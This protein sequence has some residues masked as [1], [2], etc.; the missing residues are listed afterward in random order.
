MSLPSASPHVP[1]KSTRELVQA[2]AAQLLE[3]G[4][5]VRQAAIREAILVEHGISA[6]PNLVND[7][8][9]KFWAKAGPALSARLRRPGIPDAVCQ[10]FDAIWDVALNAAAAGHELERQQLQAHTE[11]ALATA[12]QAGAQA[13]A[14]AAQL[15]AQTEELLSLR[16]D[17]SRMSEQMVASEAE[18]QGLVR[19]RQEVADKV[20]AQRL[21]AAHEHQRLQALVDQ[22][23]QQLSALRDSAQ[24]DLLALGESHQAELVKTQDFLMLETARVRD[25]HKARTERLSKELEQQQAR[26]DQLRLLRA[27]ASDE[28]AELR[29][30]LQA[31]DRALAQLEQHNA[32][33]TAQ[34]QALQAA[35]LDSV[36]AASVG[37]AK[38]TAEPGAGDTPD[39][40][41]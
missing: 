33:L 16:A 9:K 3:H 29:G 6:S 4:E 17:K 18:R 32:Q 10:Q 14:S 24:R 37:Q 7:E 36:K 39:E 27:N 40:E 34:Q 15:E 12:E 38:K 23:Q 25:E 35:L 13:R 26:N 41:G 30:R 5:E 11:A 1:L 20:E 2:Y 8:V 31:T 21:Q 19:E 22:L 28:A